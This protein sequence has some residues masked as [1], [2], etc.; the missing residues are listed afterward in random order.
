M[1]EITEDNEHKF[2]I[3]E[4]DMEHVRRIYGCDESPLHYQIRPR[5]TVEFRKARKSTIEDFDF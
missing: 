2:E 1:A 5:G 3:T 4:E